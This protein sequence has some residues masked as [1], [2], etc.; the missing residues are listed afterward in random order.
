MLNIRKNI[1]PARLS[2]RIWSKLTMTPKFF[3]DPFSGSQFFVSRGFKPSAA[4]NNAKILNF[5]RL[6]PILL[7]LL[8]AAPI[9]AQSSD[10]YANLPQTLSLQGFPQLGYPS[11]LVNV[12]IYAA[13]DDPAS[14]QFWTQASDK[15]LQRVRNGE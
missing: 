15:L 14:G 4:L 5:R 8:I 1:M 6:L 9:Y 7:L 10:R 12:K 11:A 3:S 13:F 2:N